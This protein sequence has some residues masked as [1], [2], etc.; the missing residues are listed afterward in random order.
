MTWRVT[1]QSVRLMRDTGLDGRPSLHQTLLQSGSI[2][3]CVLAALN[4]TQIIL[5]GLQVCAEWSLT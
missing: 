5:T 1:Y 4:T 3:F 2:Y